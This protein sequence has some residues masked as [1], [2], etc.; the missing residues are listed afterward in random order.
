[1]LKMHRVQIGL[2]FVATTAF[3]IASGE[4]GCGNRRSLDLFNK[5][6]ARICLQVKVVDKKKE[7]AVLEEVVRE[8]D[9]RENDF[10]PRVKLSIKEVGRICSW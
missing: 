1:M 7:K 3:Q 6:F 8:L 9:K 10:L 5:E 4:V 2:E